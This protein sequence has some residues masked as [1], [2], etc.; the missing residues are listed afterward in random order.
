M[1]SAKSPPMAKYF[2]IAPQHVRDT[3]RTN[4]GRPY[5]LLYQ[6]LRALYYGS[7]YHW[8]AWD[9]SIALYLNLVYQVHADFDTGYFT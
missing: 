6:D 5:G 2:H 4:C 9:I 1:F 3:E 7:I 8:P